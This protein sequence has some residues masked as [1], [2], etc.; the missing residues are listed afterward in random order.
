MRRIIGTPSRRAAGV[1]YMSSEPDNL[2]DYF[3][4]CIDGRRKRRHALYFALSADKQE[5]EADVARVLRDE[6]LR[7]G[8]CF[9]HSIQSRGQGDD[10]PDCEATGSNKERV[11]IEVTELVDEAA[12]KG[13]VR[14]TVVPDKPKT[15]QA[16]IE[17]ISEVVREKDCASVRGGPFDLYILV[18]YCDDA[19]FLDYETM[20]AIRE[21]RFTRPRLIDRAFFLASYDPWQRCCPYIELA[22]SA[23]SSDVGH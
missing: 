17:R 3:A 2:H 9:Y 16:V 7:R 6:M 1:T 22:W 19:C 18:V 12:V 21:T 8:E 23:N 11:G 20:V 4:T 13:A 14:G 10:P 5:N 15:P